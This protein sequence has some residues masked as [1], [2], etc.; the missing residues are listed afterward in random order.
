MIC[1]VFGGFD[2][3]TRQR[4]VFTD[5]QGGGNGGRPHADGG[6]DTPGWQPPALLHEYAG[7]S[8]RAALFYP[9]P[10][11]MNLCLTVAGAGKIQG[12]LRRCGEIFVD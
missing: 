5:I 7:R 3:E 4:F 1:V 11:A 12:Q 10:S 6:S 9:H 2:S 8:D